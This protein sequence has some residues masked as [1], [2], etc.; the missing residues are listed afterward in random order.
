MQ[1]ARTQKAEFAAKLGIVVNLVLAVVKG[2]TGVLSNSKALIADAVNSASDVVGSMVVLIGI[3][4]SKLPPDEDHPYGHG[5]AEM[6]A[7][8]IV[9]VIICIIGIQMGMSAIKTIWNGVAAPPKSFALF[10][11]VGT[12]IIKEILFQYKHRLGKKIGSHALVVNAWDHRSDVYASFAAL[13]GVSGAILGSYLNWPFAYYLDPIAGI[14]VSIIVL[15]MGY[16]LAAEAIHNTMDHVLHKEQTEELVQLVKQVPGVLAV[17]ELRAREHGY[18]IIIDLKISVN[19]KISVLEGH[20]IARNVK[21]FL[22]RKFLHVTDVFVHVNPYDPKFN[23]KTNP[24]GDRTD[25][26]TIVH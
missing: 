7:A 21:Q 25:Y 14:V 20:D 12:I 2:I 5:K 23:A 19:P 24:N 6:I 8:I 22:L 9:S 10:V 11:L 4:A 17:D 15:K 3:R 26:P 1:D 18:Y 16:R 13:I